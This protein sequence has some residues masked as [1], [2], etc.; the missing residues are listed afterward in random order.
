VIKGQYIQIDHYG[1]LYLETC[2]FCN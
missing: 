2:M 1:Q